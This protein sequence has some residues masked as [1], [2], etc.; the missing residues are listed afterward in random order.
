MLLTNFHL[1]SVFNVEKTLLLSLTACMLCVMLSQH[2]TE[3]TGLKRTRG[4]GV[5]GRNLTVEGEQPQNSS[6]FCNKI[7]SV[8]L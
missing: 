7:M 2:L 5:G 1:P 6:A 3:R 4:G 8:M